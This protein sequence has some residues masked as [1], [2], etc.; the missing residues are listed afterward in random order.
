MMKN[1]NIKIV[2]FGLAK[3]FFKGQMLK[4]FAGSPLNMAPQILKGHMYDQ[5][6][7]VYSAGTILYEMLF[8]VCPFSSQDLPTL[9]KKIDKQNMN[10]SDD[11]YI[12]EN[13]KHI[14]KKMLQ[15]NP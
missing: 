5:K 3:K 11:C 8:G 12:S 6:V 13:V 15:A 1:N 9:I 4:T 10:K 2:D 7:D 14:L